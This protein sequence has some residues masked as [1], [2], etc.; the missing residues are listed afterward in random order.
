MHE[1]IEGIQSAAELEKL[2]QES[3]A[4]LKE[5]TSAFSK[6]DGEPKVRADRVAA[7][8]AIMQSNKAELDQYAAS[9][10]PAPAAATPDAPPTEESLSKMTFQQIHREALLAVQERLQ[11]ELDSFKATA[12]LLPL[13][14]DTLAVEKVRLEKLVAALSARVNEMRKNEAKKEVEEKKGTSEDGCT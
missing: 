9:N 6:I 11:L 13:K 4:Q 12:D 3:E 10:T 8:Q 7:I 14:L 2:L 1:Q 5:V